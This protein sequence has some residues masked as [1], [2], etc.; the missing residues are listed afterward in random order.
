MYTLTQSL[1]TIYKISKQKILVII[2]TNLYIM[3][4]ALVVM[5]KMIYNDEILKDK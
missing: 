4:I 3:M 5:A 2:M 1:Y